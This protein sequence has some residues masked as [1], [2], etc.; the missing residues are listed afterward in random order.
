MKTKKIVVI[1]GGT[2][3]FV[4]LS[5]LKDYDVRLSAIVTMMDSGGSTGRLRDQLGVLPPGDVRQVLVALS[6]SDEI[7]RELFT[8]RF[9]NGELRGHNFGNIFLS[10]L[11]KMTGS[12]EKAIEVA[13]GLLQAKGNVIPVTFKHSELCVEL[14]DGRI[15]EGETH[16]DEPVE[17]ERDP[18]KRAFLKPKA[19]ANKKAL[20]AIKEADLILIGPGD[21]YT[22]LLV[23]ILVYGIPD[24][25]GNTKAKVAYILNL[26]TKFGQT[27]HYTASDHVYDLEKYLGKNVL[28]T[29]LVNTQRPDKEAIKWYGKHN[30]EPVVDDIVSTNYFKVT[31]RKLLSQDK[32]DKKNQDNLKRSFIR[33]DPQKLAKAVISLL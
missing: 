8:F 28:D 23:N 21:L 17:N 7:W 27:T 16:I 3:T 32:I 5:G 29:V 19:K 30:E 4:A 11:E 12:F 9:S 14:A 33:H 22:S 31:R 1:G 2:G 26:M 13:S 25:L 10:T 18:I 24:A 15:I 20:Q 6:E